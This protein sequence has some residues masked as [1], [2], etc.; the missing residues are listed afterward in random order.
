V[1]FFIASQVFR[2][3]VSSTLYEEMQRL[4]FPRSMVVRSAVDDY[5]ALNTTANL[6]I[7]YAPRYRLSFRELIPVE[8]HE[9][10][11][12]QCH[13][14][15]DSVE[16]LIVDCPPAMPIESTKVILE[17][18]RARPELMQQLQYFIGMHSLWIPVYNDLLEQAGQ[19]LKAIE[20]G[21][22]GG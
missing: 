5:Y 8:A 22:A 4:G 21:Q 18:I 12:G 11:W 19:A 9:Q 15:E 10:L 7:D 14:V 3:A 6:S 2:P 1:D 17:H 16:Y 20:S 13:R